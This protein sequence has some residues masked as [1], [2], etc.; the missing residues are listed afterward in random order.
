M[1]IMIQDL[2]YIAQIMQEILEHVLES[3]GM[4]I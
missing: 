1:I 2:D 3:L 4:Q